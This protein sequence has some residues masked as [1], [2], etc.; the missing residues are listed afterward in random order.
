MRKII[1]G[2][3][4]GL[5][6]FL[7]VIGLLTQF[8]A[9]GAVEKTPLDVNSVT[10]L[11]GTAEKLNLETGELEDLE[12][13]ATS[14]TKADSER[15]DDEVVVFVNT[16]CLLIDTGE[17]TP[18]CVDADDPQNRLISASTDVFATDRHDAEAVNGRYLPSGSEEKEGLVNKWPFNTEKKDYEYWDGLLGEAV[19]AVY[20]ETETIDGL[21][22]YKF[23]VNIPESAV[24]IASGVQGLYTSDREIWIEPTTGSIIRQAWHEV[25]TLENGDPI[26]DLTLGY[27]DEEIADNVADAKDS[28]GQLDLITGTVPLIGLIGGVILLLVGAVLAFGGR[29]KQETA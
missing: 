12:V 7:L 8:W 27:T 10:N 17:D 26:L 9:P 22:T 1:G 3:L 18:D 4:L 14:I 15:S 19:P 2:V 29:A 21:E 23:D 25:R 11:A 20:A 13:K 6:S 24:E 16:S 28:K 5:G